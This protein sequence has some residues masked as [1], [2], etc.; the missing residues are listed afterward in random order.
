MEE[1]Y[2][3]ESIVNMISS[4]ASVCIQKGSNHATK[5]EIKLFYNRDSTFEEIF[6]KVKYWLCTSFN[7]KEETYSI[8]TKRK[9]F[10]GNISSYISGL[11][12]IIKKSDC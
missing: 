7:G 10:N 9:D 11:Q 2:L 5:E 3:V 6:E 1:K 12:T 8:I 4:I